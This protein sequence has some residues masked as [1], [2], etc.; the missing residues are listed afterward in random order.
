MKKIF[1]VLAVSCV[2][3]AACGGG[4][5]NNGAKVDVPAGISDLQKER[6]SGNVESVRQRVYWALEKFGRKTMG[7]LQNMPVQDY[8]KIYD[9][10]GFLIEEI[11]YDAS[12]KEVS[13]KKIE[14]GDKRL[15]T[16]EEFYKD[17]A[18]IESIVYAYNDEH[19]LVKKEKIGGDGQVKEWNEY[20]YKNGLL[21][22]EDLYKD[23]KLTAKFVH[24]YKDAQLIERQKYW[25]GG[26]LAQ[27]EYYYYN[28]A[29]Q[30]EELA[31]EKYNNKIPAFELRHS[32]SDYNSWGDYGLRVEYDENGDE[33]VNTRYSYDTYGNLLESLSTSLKL[34]ETAAA[35]KGGESEDKGVDAEENEED[36]VV[37]FEELQTGNAYTYEYDEQKNWTQKITYKINITARGE[38]ERIRQFY[39]DR[40]I[41]YR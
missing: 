25:G 1:F 4:G 20:T 33:K 12:D 11:H 16:K 21:E 18:L 3:C 24:V 17:A 13:R 22:D 9:E 8:L 27:K 6:L 26:S 23:G 39:Y 29:G 41:T 32:Y 2:L 7:K 10:D 5:K 36:I 15:V 35:D 14:Y 34:V 31:A 19:Q 37:Q 38:Q 30:L 28:A 40:V